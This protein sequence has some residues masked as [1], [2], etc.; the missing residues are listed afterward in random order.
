M[1][2]CGLNGKH[3]QARHGLNGAVCGWAVQ[4]FRDTENTDKCGAN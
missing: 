3:G 1:A 4:G 2:A